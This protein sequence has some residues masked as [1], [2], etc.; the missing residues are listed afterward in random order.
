MVQ[1][2][3]VTVATADSP[4]PRQSRSEKQ[5][6][7]RRRN[8]EQRKGIPPEQIQ[9]KAATSTTRAELPHTSAPTSSYRTTHITQD[10]DLS[11]TPFL[12][13]QPVHVAGASRQRS[14]PGSLSR[15]VPRHVENPPPEVL[16]EALKTFYKLGHMD[17]DAFNSINAAVEA[18]EDALANDDA[19][20][21]P[22]AIAEAK[23]DAIMRAMTSVKLTLPGNM[24]DG[25]VIVGVKV[26]E[27]D[28]VG[29]LGIGRLKLPPQP[30]MP[31]I[32]P[33][34]D[35]EYWKERIADS[36]ARY[37]RREADVAEDPLDFSRA[38]YAKG[39]PLPALSADPNIKAQQL[40][41]FQRDLRD[42]P[43]NYGPLVHARAKQEAWLWKPVKTFWEQMFP[44][45]YEVVDHSQAEISVP[46][47]VGPPV[48]VPDAV[49]LPA[50]YKLDD[51][52][53]VKAEVENILAQLRLPSLQSL[54]KNGNLPKAD[55]RTPTVDAAATDNCA[56]V[57]QS[58][59]SEAQMVKDKNTTTPSV[60]VDSAA[61][62]STGTHI[63]R[64]RL[65]P[66]T[67]PELFAPWEPSHPNDVHPLLL[68]QADLDIPFEE[69]LLPRYLYKHS[70]PPYDPQPPVQ[71]SAWNLAPD[72]AN[73]EASKLLRTK[74]VSSY[75]DLPFA[76]IEEK[77]ERSL[78]YFDSLSPALA[79][80]PRRCAPPTAEHAANLRR[81]IDRLRRQLGVRD[82]RSGVD[83][84]AAEDQG[85]RREARVPAEQHLSRPHRGGLREEECNRQ[86]EKLG[87]DGQE[88]DGLRW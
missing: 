7:R 45:A 48:M 64:P 59:T 17:A 18:E 49:V 22:E 72:L 20:H 52:P 55:A 88:F 60:K 24:E 23:L 63:K 11:S 78:S 25:E 34:Q 14:H 71:P 62:Q 32:S 43:S 73:L 44:E 39:I 81:G 27:K 1:P 47:Y 56:E 15:L 67:H 37:K 40:A 29:D 2:R 50:D 68:V 77:A 83:G 5:R 33:I 42:N 51:K 3:A 54:Q 70:T 74:N 76:L 84:G 35:D 66:S 31:D 10:S 26:E 87:L 65:H 9:Q 58:S 79:L 82:G 61:I 30:L 19:D 46:R 13:T 53:E 8:R 80:Q 41:K 86:G 75:Q 36:Y 85:R 69:L 21:T 6:E 57:H 16:L 28:E 4:S 12:P 38:S